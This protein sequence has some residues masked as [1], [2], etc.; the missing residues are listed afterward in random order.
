MPD[1]QRRR[2]CS[3]MELVVLLSLN[4][5]HDFLSL[6]TTALTT[7]SDKGTTGRQELQPK[8]LLRP[9]RDNGRHRFTRDKMDGRG[10]NQTREGC[11]VIAAA[12]NDA[13][14]SLEREVDLMKRRR[15]ECA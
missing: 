12:A 3:N 6:Q 9:P 7:L 5:F 13:L 2:T 14:V 4:T 11:R 8:V 1:K 10:E 15:I